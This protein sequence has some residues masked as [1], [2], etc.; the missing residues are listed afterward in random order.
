[1]SIISHLNALTNTRNWFGNKEQSILRGIFAGT[2]KVLPIVVTIIMAGVMLG[3]RIGGDFP[4]YAGQLASFPAVCFESTNALE[5]FSALGDLVSKH[6]GDWASNGFVQY[7]ILFSDLIVIGFIFAI[8]LS[9]KIKHRPNGFR[10]KAGLI[11][12]TASTVATTGTLCW[13]SVQYIEMRDTMEGNAEWYNGGGVSNQYS[14]YN[15]VTWALFVSSLV[16]VA[17]AFSG[18]SL[19]FS[20][21]SSIHLLDLMAVE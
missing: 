9:K 8:A 10:M 15:V 3:A 12:R 5:G 6:K 20:Q 18:M 21:S 11:L 16:P 4:S 7:L 19:S 14:Y 2:V 1:M 13:L 17:K